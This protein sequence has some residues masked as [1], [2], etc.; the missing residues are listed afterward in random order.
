MNSVPARRDFVKIFSI[1]P[2]IKRYKWK[3]ISSYWV[4]CIEL[5]SIQAELQRCIF[6]ATRADCL[7]AIPVHLQIAEQNPGREVC[8]FCREGLTLD[9]LDQLEAQSITSPVR[10]SRG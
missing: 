1:L 6:P 2:S 7:A 10:P 4:L 5:S 8:F 9:P 3:N